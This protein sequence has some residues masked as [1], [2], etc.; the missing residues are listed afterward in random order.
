MTRNDHLLPSRWSL[1]YS[2]AGK[3][4]HIY[5]KT[6]NLCSCPK[7]TGWE[8]DA[9]VAVKCT[10]CINT[11]EKIVNVIRFSQDMQTAV[12]LTACSYSSWNKVSA[13]AGTIINTCLST[14]LVT[15]KNPHLENKSY[16]TVENQD[17]DNNNN[18]KNKTCCHFLHTVYRIEIMQGFFFV[19][20]LCATCYIDLWLEVHLT[21]KHYENYNSSV[22]WLL[23][24]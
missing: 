3:P 9:E 5:V 23:H 18:K 7:I 4:P 8:I 17:K 20:D 1:V 16:F 24:F 2:A 11:P 12:A 15:K 22:C 10:V 13:V 19:E 14:F 21:M 6:C